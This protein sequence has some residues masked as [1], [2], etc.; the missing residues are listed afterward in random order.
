MSEAEEADEA[1]EQETQP[2]P[3][4]D[5][6]FLREKYHAEELTQE[7]IGQ[8]D[9]V[10][11]HHGGAVTSSTVSHYMN[12]HDVETRA[13]VIEDDRLDDEE[14]LQAA[15][16]GEVEGLGD[17]DGATMQQI[18][19]EIGCSDGTIMRRLHQIEG[20]EIR[21]SRDSDDDGEDEDA[22]DEGPDD[23]AESEDDE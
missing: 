6:E 12:K 1:E 23:E 13:N 21:R 11:E 8:L 2:S 20:L 19:D 14:W 5:P 18:A 22:E 16:E 17:E 7:E 3:L 4:N 10:V 9:E 15:Y